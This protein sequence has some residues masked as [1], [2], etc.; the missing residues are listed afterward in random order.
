MDEPQAAVLLVNASLVSVREVSGFIRVIRKQ[1]VML[2]SDLAALYGVETRRLIEQLKRNPERFPP[3]FCF[4]LSPDEH[5]ALRTQFAI[6]KG[7]GGRRTPPYAFTEQGVAMLSSV[8][9]SPRAVSVNIEIMR[10]FVRTRGMLAS[11]QDLVKR[12]DELEAKYDQ[13]L[14]LVFDAIRALGA[15]PPAPTR[16]LGFKATGSSS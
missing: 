2:D 12:L 6:S 5:A 13:S 16:K 4:Q 7:R 14:K 15:P 3:D 11:H 1:P 9:N 8:L 10:S